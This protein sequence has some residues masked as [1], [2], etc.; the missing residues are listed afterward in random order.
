MTSIIYKFCNRYL[1]FLGSHNGS[2]QPK[3]SPVHHSSPHPTLAIGY[4]R[5][6]QDLRTI[7]DSLG[8]D[9]KSFS[10]HSMKRG[11]TTTS[12]EIGIPEAEICQEGGWK[13][14]KTM[15]LYIDK[16]DVKSLLFAK[17]IS[18]A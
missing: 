10:E 5:A 17:K 15:R 7:L 9:G 6:I 8:Y 3:C 1:E 11:I 14:L 2:L 4:N 12:D 16:K 13:N 18:K